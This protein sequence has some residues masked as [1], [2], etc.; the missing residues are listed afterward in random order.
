MGVPMWMGI[1][2]AA[3]CGWFL[4]CA[5]HR[6]DGPLRGW[7]GT[8]TGLAAALLAVWRVRAGGMAVETATALVL[9]VAMLAVPC[10]SYWQ[11]RRRRAARRAR[12]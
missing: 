3:A 6:A 9:G 2:L 7:P 11:A 1:L 5:T 12:S 8:L 4:L 10:W